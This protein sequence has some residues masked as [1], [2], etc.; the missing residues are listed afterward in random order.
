MFSR[1]VYLLAC[2]SLFTDMASEML[3]PVMPAYLK[4]IGFSVALIGLLEGLA[5]AVAGLSKGYFGKMSDRMGRRA[6]FIQWGY[7]LSALSKPML[8]FWAY[9]LWV[10]LARTTDRLG[11]GLRSGARDALLSEEAAPGALGRVFGF[12]RATDTLGAVL[13]PLCALVYLYFFPEDYIRLFYLAFIPGLLAVGATLFLRDQSEPRQEKPAG[14]SFFAFT[15]YW[16]TADPAYRRLVG[17]LLVF[18]L[19]NSSDVFLLLRARESG[20]D[21]ATVI[22]V[23]IL[24][25]LTYALAAYPMGIFAD[26]LGLKKVFILGLLLFAAV[27]AGFAWAQGLP[28]F[29]GLFVLYGLYAAATEGISKAWISKVSGRE[30]RATAIGFYTGF[31]SLAALI[32]STLMGAVWHFWGS[33]P[34]FGLA[35]AGTVGVAVYMARAI[36]N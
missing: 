7:G 2:I 12:H 17:G 31:Q 11:K 32:A 23:Y 21:D 18:A 8:A 5:E 35:A 36:K 25:N 34:A 30:D 16:K 9:P 15:G 29:V 28:A 3:Y 27:Y 1:T 19:I 6:P 33:A 14:A 22:G 10:F 4:H 20:L 24:Y 13:G 26:R